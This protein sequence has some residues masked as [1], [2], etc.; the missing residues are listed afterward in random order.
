MCK[1]PWYLHK[2]QTRTGSC[3]PQAEALGQPYT[4]SSMMMMMIRYC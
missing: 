1:G 3:S 2:P 4:G